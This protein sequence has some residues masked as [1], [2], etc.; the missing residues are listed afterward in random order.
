MTRGKKHRAATLC[1]CLAAGAAL[2]LPAAAG[3]ASSAQ[4]EYVLTLP[5]V[6]TNNA[7]GASALE[8]RAERAGP[9]GVVGE[10]DGTVTALGAVGTAFGTPAGIAVAVVLAVAVALA[11]SRRRGTS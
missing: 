5:G 2:L 6:D 1:L 9:S 10:Q 7:T 3:A 4:E 11:L 8:Q